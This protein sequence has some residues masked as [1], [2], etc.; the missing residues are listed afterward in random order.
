MPR[1]P[2][3]A[4]FVSTMTM[5]TIDIQTDYFTPCAYAPGNYYAK[6]VPSLHVKYKEA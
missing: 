1:S 3:V 2:K 4:I 6:I 5:L